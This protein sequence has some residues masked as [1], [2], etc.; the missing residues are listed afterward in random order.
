MFIT[1]VLSLG[2]LFTPFSSLFALRF[3][4][5]FLTL[6][7]LALFELVS[8]LRLFLEFQLSGS[9]LFM[10]LYSLCLVPLELLSLVNLVVVDRFTAYALLLTGGK[11]T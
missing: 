6:D 11:L 8:D 1:V 7:L 4:V 3:F 10:A 2:E 5:G 9:R